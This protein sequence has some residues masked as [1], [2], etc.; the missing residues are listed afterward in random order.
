MINILI[1]L[2]GKDTFSTDSDNAFPKILSDVSGELLIERAA[3]AFIALNYE[4]K[5]VIAIPKKESEKYQLNRVLPLLDEQIKLCNI[6]GNTQGAACSA[7]LAVESLNLDAPLII[8][9]FEQVLDFDLKPY[10]EDFFENDVDAGVLTFEAIHPK[11]SY[12]KVCDEGWVTQAAEKMPISKNAIAGFY[13]YKSARHFVEA[14]QGMIRKDVKTNGLFFI[15][16]TINE[17]ILNGGRVKA[18][19]IDKKNYFHINDVH[20]LELY[21]ENIVAEQHTKRQKLLKLTTDYVQ[22]FDSKDIGGVE[23]FFSDNFKLRDPA[24]SIKGKKEV[25]NYIEGIFNSVKSLQFEAKNILVTAE[26]QS[27]IEFELTIDGKSLIG[28]DVIQWDKDFKMLD[29]NAYL[30]EKNNG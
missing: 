10:V 3:K 5:I 28:T 9:S 17:I 30:Y 21:E 22:A 20:S 24:V 6:N 4:K 23:Q 25:T 8:S 29:M 7:L 2:A 18:I 27:I 15:A 1:P 11:W 19:K 16:P 14:A 12:V 13:F 26:L